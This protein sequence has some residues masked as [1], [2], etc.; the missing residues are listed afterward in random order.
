[1]TRAHKQ[2]ARKDYPAQG[3]KKGDEYYKWQFNFSKVVHRSKVKPT[4]S[5]LTQSSF[6]S[7]L[8]ELEDNISF[9]R[10]AL[11]DSVQS[12]V[13][14]IEQ[15][16]DECQ[17]SL[18]NMPEHLQEASQSGQTL[19]ER[20]EA[21]DNW[22][23]DLEGVDLEVDEELTEEE[24]ESRIDDIINELEGCSSGLLL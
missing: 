15:L 13:S 2:V 4:R 9:D 19:T 6:L 22:I 5:Q 7:Q 1:M 14:D 23:S 20:I 8:Y 16:R 21:L 17:D 3:I 12:L 10:D 11:E 18:D 24:K